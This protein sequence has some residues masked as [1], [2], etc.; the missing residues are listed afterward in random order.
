MKNK[1]KDDDDDEKE[2]EKERDTMTKVY[3]ILFPEQLLL[4]R[5]SRVVAF[6]VKW[7]YFVLFQQK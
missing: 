6:A 4:G 3:D 1:V 5:Q 2:R 7:L